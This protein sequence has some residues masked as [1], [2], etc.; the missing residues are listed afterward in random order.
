MTEIKNTGNEFLK[1]LVTN[2]IGGKKLAIHAYDKMMWMVR[3]GFLTLVFAGW[4]IL[5]KSVI[6]AKSDLYSI[7]PYIYILSAF[8]LALA[9]AGYRIDINYAKRK[10]RVIAS[11]NRLMPLVVKFNF[12]NIQTE[13][14][15][16]LVS[17]LKIS[18]DA[19]NDIYKGKSFNNEL[20]VSRLIFFVPAGLIL[21]ILVFF[22]SLV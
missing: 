10:F 6:D 22:L 15:D 4:S 5:I 19:Y 13:E 18:G 8:S 16:E 3:S 14:E 21:G 17:L 7:T 12:E 9:I 2:E 20:N 1:T 11:V